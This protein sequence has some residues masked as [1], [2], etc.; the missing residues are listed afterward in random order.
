MNSCPYCLHTELRSITN[1]A[2]REMHQCL[3]CRMRFDVGSQPT[4][5]FPGKDESPQE[6]ET[7]AQHDPSRQA[8]TS[9]DSPPGPPSSAGEAEP[10]TASD[11]TPESNPADSTDA[12]PPPA[13]TRRSTRSRKR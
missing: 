8:H 9:D 7:H 1:R 13:P 4:G 10:N 5:D 12:D 11:E 3:R 6:E 2:G